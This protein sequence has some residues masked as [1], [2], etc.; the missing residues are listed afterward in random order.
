M[1]IDVVSFGEKML[2]LS[3][4]VGTRLEDAR[5]FQLYVAGS[6]SNMLSCMS[7]LGLQTYWLSALP[8]TPLGKLVESELR[9]HGVHTEAVQWSASHTRLGTYYAE[10]SP[11]P[12]GTQVYYDRA[13]SACANINPDAVDYSI[14]DSARLLHLTGITPALSEQA[15]S[16]FSRL[17][18]R[19]SEKHIPISFDVNYRA[20][21]WTSVDAARGIEEACQ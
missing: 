13:A 7:R 11:A 3:P 6:E 8:L 10:E 20:K 4:P 21:L 16:V 17:L 15:R 12:L 18:H 9:R 19:A 1:S 14:V 5:T 2:R